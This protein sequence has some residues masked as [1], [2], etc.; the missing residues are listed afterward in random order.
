MTMIDHY[1]PRA[2]RRVEEGQASGAYTRLT[3]QPLAPTIG[4]EVSG[5]DLRGPFDDELVAELRRAI[6]EWKVLFFRDQH[7]T[8]DEHRAFALLWGE[9]E[10]HP[11]LRQGEVPEVVRFEKGAD[12]PG[13]ENN[14]HSD[15]TWREVPS[16]GSVLRA[17]D[18]PDVGGDT[19]WADMAAAY[20]G[21]PAEVKAR[22]DGLHAVHDFTHTFGA[23][24]TEEQLHGAQAA[25]PPATHPV[26]RTIPETGRKVL[27]VNAVFTSHI[28]GLPPEESASLLALL[29][30]QASV[31]EYQCRFRWSAGSVA[32]WD[33]RTTQHYANSDYYPARR[34]ME[35]ATIIGDRPV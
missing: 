14:W 31:P 17:V 18:V 2:L 19:L 27:Y 11:F 33:N 12:E 25:Y 26:V 15:V 3:V 6:L 35:R 28:V 24:M 7:L 29:S 1:G 32:W 16:F 20:D 22:V 13:L 21:L 30:R 23:A 10:V 34:V 9:L 5:V 4:A 8:G